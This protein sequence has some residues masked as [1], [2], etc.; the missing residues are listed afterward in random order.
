MDQEGFYI[1][2][3]FNKL[4]YTK[5]LIDSGC[6]CYMAVSEKFARQAQLP[7]IEIPPR[8]LEEVGTTTK[9]AITQVAYADID[10]DGYEQ[11]RV[12]CYVIPRQTEDVIL[13]LPWQKEQD[14][15]T[16]PRDRQ[17][18]LRAPGVWI[19]QR[20][21]NE[22]PKTRLGVLGAHVFRALVRRECKRQKS[23]GR[24]TAVFAAS[25]K[26][27]DKALKTKTYTDPRTKLPLHYHEFLDAFSREEA[28]QLPPHRPGIDHEIPI[29]KNDEGQEKTLPWGPLYSMSKEELL[30]LRKTL[31]ELLDK[32]FIRVSSSPASAPVLFVKKPG[33]GLRFCVDYRALNAITRKDRYPLPLITETLRS[34][35]R[36]R[37]YTKVDVIAAFHKI[38]IK[39]GDEWKT[40][41][42]TRYG[43]FEWL[44][45][46]FGMTSAPA[47]FQRYINWVLREHL[48]D[49]CTAY[50]DDVLIYSDGS[51]DDHRKKVRKVLQKLQDA[52]LQ[53]D[54][55]K[56]EFEAKSV[57]YLGYI[58]E[59]GAGVRADPAKVEAV[60]SW[61]T[62]KTVK[63]VRSFLGFANYYRE[64]IPQFSTVAAPLTELTKKDAPFIWSPR[65]EEAFQALKELLISAP[66]LA[67]WDPERK[68]VV[69]TDSSGYTIGGVLSQY[70][71]KE[72]LR[73]VAYFSKKVLPAEAN[74]L[75]H[76]K[77][78]LAVIRCL[79][80]WDA[81]LRS[82]PEF[83][84]LTDH[85]NL[86]YFTTK[87]QLTERQMRWAEIL[88]RYNFTLAYRPGTQ[89]GRAD[90][91]SRREQD[92][93]K[94]L[95]DDRLLGRQRQLLETRPDGSLRLAKDLREE[96]GGGSQ[97][98]KGPR[99]RVGTVWVMGGDTDQEGDETPDY[100]DPPENPFLG[101]PDLHALWEQALQENRRYWL[102]RRAVIGGDRQLPPK[103][104][105]PI[106]L[107]ECSVDGGKRL[108]WREKIW[109]PNFEPLRTKIIQTTHDS[110]L[111][112]HPGRDLTRFLVTRTFTWPGLSQDVRRF[113]RNCNVCG[114][115]SVWRDKKQG[116]LK[117]LP[118]PE[119]IWSDLS[120]DFI[121]GLPASGERRCTNIMVVT[122]RLSKAVILEPMATITTEDVARAL[123]TSLIRHHGLP[124]R[125]VSDRGTQFV[126]F[127]WKRICELLG[128]QRQ[129]STAFHPET[130][131]ATE[132]VNQVIEHYLRAYTAYGQDDWASLLPIAMLAINNRTA[133]STG[134]SPF[135]LTHGYDTNA[136]QVSEPLRETGS[137]PIARGE[138]FVAKLREAQEWA[139]AAMASAQETQER[140]ANRSR[141]VAERF[142]VGDQVWLNLKNIV[143]D[144]PSKKLDW[145]HAK[146]TVTELIGSHS[147]RLNTPPG[148]HDVYHVSLLRRAAND[149]LPSQQQDDTQPP[150]MATIDGDDWWEVEEI[151]G[152]RRKGR[153]W[154]V[155][156][157][158]QGYTQPTWEPYRELQGTDAMKAYEA[159]YGRIT[160]TED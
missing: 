132:R 91:L 120:V 84:I 48:D 135:F 22:D 105:L 52:G 125:I 59:A 140:Y 31:T 33:G 102:I 93:P 82:V 121:V 78:L 111:T 69:E 81:E 122:D 116:V 89:N 157:K 30:V 13:G 20:D 85:K 5:A 148:R 115:T 45:T 156:V 151:K 29:Q 153:G 2:I 39:E 57:K 96:A 7:R 127:M 11:Q 149:P 95:Q 67:H 159:R 80:E 17:L 158:W 113:L 28:D 99:T 87:Q 71:E 110:H 83:T 34:L 12:Y 6:G 49:F 97:G 55:D 36:A 143:T 107:S 35:S 77:E 146:Y 50:M 8:D 112:G 130:D 63:G 56:S 100:S 79:Q 64:F 15:V 4:T 94:D 128:I 154:Q 53:L 62:P 42:R 24:T 60:K 114:R 61:E 88:S 106:S 155:L 98:S 37:W 19:R 104:G 32:N 108:L 46:P 92:T 145:L 40:A 118:V 123:L 70:D 119:R 133:T 134:I 1:N 129:L 101:D 58:I 51:L 141:A 66:I 72:R 43:L 76:D 26:D 86:E 138:A 68:T 131:G 90:A 137:S 147:C 54:I 9:G 74:Y 109:V 18:H 21:P 10:L 142:E 103:W 117:P 152:R 136:I 65:C 144:R 44:V 3:G 16:Y 41:F 23:Q 14:V 25:M 38:R 73:P 47:T 126:S 27:I 150:A 124:A 139:Q 160:S 75:I